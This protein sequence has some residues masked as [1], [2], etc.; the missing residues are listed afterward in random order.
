[1][2]RTGRAAILD[3]EKGNFTV[4]EAVVPDPGSGELLVRQC[5][6]RRVRH[7]R[8]TFYNGTA[9]KPF[10]WCWAMKSSA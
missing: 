1:M 8:C 2:A 9:R 5:D 10:R 6:V 4:G 7:G 3:G